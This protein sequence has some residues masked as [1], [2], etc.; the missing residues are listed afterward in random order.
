MKGKCIPAMMPV[1]LLHS[2]ISPPRIS[3]Y[4]FKAYVCGLEA[5]IVCHQ[6]AHMCASASHLF[7]P[8]AAPLPV[9]LP[10]SCHLL[11][12][13]HFPRLPL[14]SPP[15]GIRSFLT[16]KLSWNNI[17]AFPHST[18]LWAGLDGTELLTH[19]PPANTYNAQVRRTG[20]LG[21]WAGLCR[22]QR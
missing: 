5:G 7:P 12:L 17:N 18:F 14:P 16:Q 6:R 22:M 4:W 11:T 10:T 15:P 2:S 21:V 8:A 19:F 3:R 9:F 13:P 1:V 20:G